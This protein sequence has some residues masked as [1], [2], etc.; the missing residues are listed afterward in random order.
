MGKAGSV[1]PPGPTAVKP[2]LSSLARLLEGQVK[3][4][5]L[6]LPG[7][8]LLVA[9]SGGP[10]S[11]AL[12][13]LL[14]ELAP[15]WGL[16][17]TAI[18]VNHGLRGEESEEDARFAARLCRDLGIELRSARPSLEPPKAGRRRSSLQERARDA[19][20]AVLLAEGRA[21]AIDRIALGHQADDQAETLLMW[22]LRGAGTKIGRASCRERV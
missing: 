12:L 9:V 2:R 4:Q 8:R 17:L 14:S 22:M 21:R 10:D 5:H 13:S 15:S 20:Y 7:A 3:S 6:F 1:A 18:H 11:V 19:R 16:G